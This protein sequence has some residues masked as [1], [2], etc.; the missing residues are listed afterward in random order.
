MILVQTRYSAVFKIPKNVVYGRYT[1]K[2]DRHPLYAFYRKFTATAKEN[3]GDI[4][5]LKKI[6]QY[7]IFT[8]RCSVLSS[9]GAQFQ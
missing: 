4:H 7:C 1:F 3:A 8:A 6:F 9:T 2:R 5:L